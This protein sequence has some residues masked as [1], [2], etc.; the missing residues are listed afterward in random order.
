MATINFFI[1]GTKNPASIYV[2]LRNGRSADF[3]TSSGYIIDPKHWNSNKGEVKQS[4]LFDDKIN[5]SRDLN[6][7]RNKV[8]EELNSSIAKGI[9]INKQWLES[10]ISNEDSKILD[11]IRASSSLWINLLILV[12]KNKNIATYS[13]K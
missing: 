13:W 12:L 2:R 5:L 9:V 11:R 4:A 10:V 6:N 8:I 1:K 3:T 7:M